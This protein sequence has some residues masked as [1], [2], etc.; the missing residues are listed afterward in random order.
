MHPRRESHV[1]RSPHVAHDPHAIANA[2]VDG[3]D[4]NHVARLERIGR[5]AP[6]REL[7]GRDVDDD[8][9]AVAGV[10]LAWR[11]H[12][13]D[14][15]APARCLRGESACRPQ[16][17][18]ER[19]TALQLVGRGTD[20]LAVHTNARAVHGHKDHV[21]RLKP[22]IVRT[23]RPEEVV[24]QVERIHEPAAA[25]NLD[26]PHAAIDARPAGG[27][28]RTECG[29]GAG[30]AIA[31]R[32]VHVTKD[33]HLVAV[34]PRKVD[35]E[36]CRG[37]RAATQAGIDA[38]KARVQDILELAERE[39]GNRDLPDP[40][41]DDEA[42]ARD[43]ERVGPLGISGDDEDD[44]IAGPE[45]VARVHG[46][47]EVG[48]ELRR[49]RVEDAEAKDGEAAVRRRTAATPGRRETASSRGH[50]RQAKR[51]VERQ[52]VRSGIP[53]TAAAS[54]VS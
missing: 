52:R 33:E 5:P 17:V 19:F 2:L 20:D 44:A 6:R 54:R 22:W 36:V 37:A 1:A 29:S 7:R 32:L 40:R 34:E 3:E 38:A 49:L 48:I 30:D 21:A 28:Q 13:R 45:P 53:D 41:N 12:P 18:G 14:L 4:A 43:V 51:V 42:L 9:R 8:A 35:G 50:V 26:A 31:A 46:A 23:V 25:A 11:Q 39:V 27:V 10:A 47:G 16:K 24:V 15:H